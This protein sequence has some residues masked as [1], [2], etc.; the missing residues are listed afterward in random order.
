VKLIN[1]QLATTAPDPRHAMVCDDV[2]NLVID[3][4]DATPST[5][6]I[7][8]LNN[9]RDATI[10]GCVPRAGTDVFLKVTHA[11]SDRIALMGND[12]SRVRKR[13]GLGEGVRKESVV[14]VG[15]K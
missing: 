3:S 1:V 10:R 14:E 9:V 4:C 5:A 12:L 6:P 13:V 2:T 11:S 15:N 7:V 8:S